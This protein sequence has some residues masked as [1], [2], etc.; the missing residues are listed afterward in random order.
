MTPVTGMT[1][2]STLCVPKIREIC[3]QCRAARET[4]QDG[5]IFQGFDTRRAVAVKDAV[6]ERFDHDAQVAR[7][8]GCGVGISVQETER[9]ELQ[10]GNQRYTG[11]DGEIGDVGIEAAD[12]AEQDEFDREDE[13]TFPIADTDITGKKFA[14]KQTDREREHRDEVG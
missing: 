6:K 1:A 3:G 14:Q 8:H 4:Q 12:D 7:A 9:T 2:N 10:C 11:R 13:Q 5:E